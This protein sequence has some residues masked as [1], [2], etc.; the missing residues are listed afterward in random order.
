MNQ[1]EQLF[2]ETYLDM[3]GPNPN[4]LE[5]EKVIG[6]YKVDFLFRDRFVIEIDGHEAHKTKEQRENDYNRERYLM[7]RGYIVIRFTGTE[8]YL[9]TEKCVSDMVE[10]TNRNWG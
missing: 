8:V 1:I 7:K 4:E 3:R 9:E 2:Y 5:P 10:I 6:L